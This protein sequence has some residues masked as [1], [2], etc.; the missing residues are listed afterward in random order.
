MICVAV[1]SGYACRASAA[2]PDTC[3]V[4]SELPVNH[5]P[6]LPVPIL[7]DWINSPGATISGFKRLCGE[8]GPRA[9]CAAIRCTLP[10]SLVEPTLMTERS[11]PGAETR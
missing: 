8:D 1:L 4:A 5:A 3:G 2:A 11:T 9:L 10:S 7:A 6:S